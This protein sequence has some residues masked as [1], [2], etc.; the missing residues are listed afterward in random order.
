MKEKILEI[1]EN[2]AW[3]QSNLSSPKARE[4]ITADIIKAL[5][6]D[7]DEAVCAEHHFR[8]ANGS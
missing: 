4:Q 3:V 6:P 1:L 8:E 2:H 5:Q 7:V